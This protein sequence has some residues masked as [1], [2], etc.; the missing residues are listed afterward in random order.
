MLLIGPSQ[1]PPDSTHNIENGNVSDKIINSQPEDF[2]VL[3]LFSPFLV[4]GR[5]SVLTVLVLI[6]EGNKH[7]NMEPIS[8]SVG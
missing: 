8:G 6:S 7:I 2:L 5:G 4:V 3:F 1:T